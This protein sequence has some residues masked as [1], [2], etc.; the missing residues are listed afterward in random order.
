VTDAL[1]SVTE[2]RNVSRNH[3][4]QVSAGLAKQFERGISAMASYTWSR[5]RDVQTPLRVN[6]RGTLNWQLTAISGRHDDPNPGISL[7]D[8]P[9]RVVL[10]GTWRAP[11]RRWLTELSLLYV[12]ESGSPFTYRAGGA[13]GRGDLNADGGLNDPLYVP[14][15]ALDPGEIVF[16]GVSAEP[17][18]DNSPAAQ[19]ARVLRQ[20]AAFEQFVASSP[21]LRRQRGRILARNSC[22]EPWAHTTA[23]SLRQ[24]IPIGGQVVEAQLDVFNL[25]N[26]LDGDWGRRRLANP[27]LLEHVGHTSGTAGAPEPVFRYLE[28]AGSWTTD[29][30]ESAFQLQFGIRYRF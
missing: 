30:A 20:R 11:W 6:T 9:H 4:V 27:V 12:G 23:A 26:L 29:P 10:A 18:A 17:G 7:N 8:V 25:L 24:A 15:S 2:L 22:R 13:G 1:P 19:D 21:C 28:S 14:R 5:V 16:T 3:S